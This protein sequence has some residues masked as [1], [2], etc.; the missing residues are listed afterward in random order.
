MY[1]NKESDL[2]PRWHRRWRNEESFRL[3]GGSTGLGIGEAGGCLWA[4]AGCSWAKA[5]S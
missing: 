5:G 2:R 1:G 4:R 3:M